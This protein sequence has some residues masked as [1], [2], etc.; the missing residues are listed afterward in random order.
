M[1]KITAHKDKDR[2]LVQDVVKQYADVNPQKLRQIGVNHDIAHAKGLDAQ[3]IESLKSL[4]QTAKQ[5]EKRRRPSEM[6]IKIEVVQDSN[7]EE[8][9]PREPSV[10]KF[11]GLSESSKKV[12]PDPEQP[13]KDT[14]TGM[15]VLAKSRYMY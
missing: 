3:D 6:K 7:E 2:P 5:P 11:V 9:K 4:Q 10:V 14:E 8:S 12:A 13:A 1:P 15:Y